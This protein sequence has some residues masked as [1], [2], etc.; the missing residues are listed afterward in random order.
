M[1]WNA[2]WSFFLGAATEKV[3]ESF[4]LGVVKHLKWPTPRKRWVSRCER[5]TS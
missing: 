4:V 1:T 3:K 5:Q 2:F